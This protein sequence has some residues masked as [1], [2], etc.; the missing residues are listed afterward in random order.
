MQPAT[1]LS[2]SRARN[3]SMLYVYTVKYLTMLALSN[4]VARLLDAGA[5]RAEYA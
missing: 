5:G 2:H 4:G 1:L 3:S